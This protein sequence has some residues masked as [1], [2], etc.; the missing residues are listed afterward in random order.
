MKFDILDEY[1]SKSYDVG[2]SNVPDP[3]KVINNKTW[4]EEKLEFWTWGDGYAVADW[5]EHHIYMKV[6]DFKTGGYRMCLLGNLPTAK[7]PDTGRSYRDIW[8]WQKEELIV[9]AC[10]RS[11]DG[12]FKYDTIVFCTPRGEGKTYVNVI[13]ALHRFF[14]FPAQ[15]IICGANSKNQSVFSVKTIAEELIFNSDRLLALVPREDIKD[16]EIRLRDSRGEVGNRLIAISAK[17]GV[18]SNASCAIFSEIFQ[19]APPFSMYYQLDSSRRNVPNSVVLVDSTVSDKNHVLYQLYDISKKP[20]SQTFFYYSYS[21]S[22]DYKDYHHPLMTQRQL[23]SFREKFIPSEFKAF[24]LNKWTGKETTFFTRQMVD[25]MEFA[26]V[27]G[28]VGNQTEVLSVCRSI[29]EKE[30]SGVPYDTEL[31]R[32]MPLPYKLESNLLP[33]FIDLDEIDKLKNLY[34]TDFALGIGIDLADPLKD[35]L[36]LGARTIVTFVLKGLPGSLS[37]PTMG[38]VD[39][40]DLDS[41]NFVYFLA[42]LFHVESSDTED[43]VKIISIGIDNIGLPYNMMVERWGSTEIYK[44]AEREDLPI[45][46]VSPVHGLQREMFN[47]LYRLMLKGMVKSPKL[48]IIGASDYNYNTKFGHKDIIREELSNFI[49]DS[50]KKFYGSKTKNRPKGIQD[51]SIYSFAYAIHS[52]RMANVQDMLISQ[53]FG[54]GK[55]SL[56]FGKFTKNKAMLV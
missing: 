37:D 31:K 15:R 48:A 30:N 53:R 25:A 14:C 8:E 19:M 5:A 28:V 21:D 33:R 47:R 55:N 46:V 12:K 36:T 41:L 52:L 16:K 26:G 20:E 44:Y 13:I 42:G 7:H 4:L 43:V 9:P 34:D 3:S 18:F 32:F 50:Q 17:H 49:Y 6:Q 35:D 10:E 38:M 56:F 1:V 51:D 29:Y 40:S 11:S 27:D 22:G 23:D 45:E 54:I 24:F 39:D 2:V